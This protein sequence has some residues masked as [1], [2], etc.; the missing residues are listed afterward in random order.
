MQKPCQETILTDPAVNAEASDTL[1]DGNSGAGASETEYP[2]VIAREEDPS[3]VH[4]APKGHQ[5]PE[6]AAQG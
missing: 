6:P 1:S 5:T 3:I 2:K 4:F